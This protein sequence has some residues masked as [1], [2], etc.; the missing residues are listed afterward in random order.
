M[1]MPPRWKIED[2]ILNCVSY[3][4]VV[5]FFSLP[6]IVLLFV[7]DAPKPPECLVQTT[8]LG[9]RLH[10]VLDCPMIPSS[11]LEASNDEK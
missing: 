10:I 11:A 3:A 9:N 7:S 6:I 1:N 4:F 8:E 5:A 2:A